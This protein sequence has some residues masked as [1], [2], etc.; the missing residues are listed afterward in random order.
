MISNVDAQKLAKSSR[1]SAFAS[2]VGIIIVILSLVYSSYRLSTL[3]KQIDKKQAQ[4]TKISHELLSI[5]EEKIKYK[6]Q[7]K[8]LEK[9]L[10]ETMVFDKNRYQMDWKRSKSLA[11]NYHTAR[12]VSDLYNMKYEGVNWKLG[13]TLPETGFDSPSFVAYLLIKEYKTLDIEWKDRYKLRDLLPRTTNPKNGDLIFYD[14]G[15][16]MFYFKDRSGHPF[17]IGMTP[18]GIVALEIE[19]GPR[20]LHFG[21]VDYKD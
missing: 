14:T 12:L 4:F 5:T 18:L 15:Y 1:Q 20:L 9:R 17:C 8:E 3:Q 19:F 2:F 16:T 11:S 21:I 7:V 13:G 10:Q 6:I